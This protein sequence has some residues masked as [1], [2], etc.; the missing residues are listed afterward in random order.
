MSTVVVAFSTAPY[1]GLRPFYRHEGDIFFGREEQTDQL[2]RRLQE[3]RFLAVVGPSGCGKSSLVRAGM[4]AGLE[5]GYMADAG[6]RWRIAEMRPG[7]R[8]LRALAATLLESADLFP[9]LGDA[10]ASLVEAA[11]RRGPRGLI[12]LLDGS[13]I[14]DGTNLLLLV[15]QFEEIFR[16]RREGDTD[17]AEAFVSLLLATAREPG[18]PVYVVLTMRS[19][20]LGDCAV[21]AGLPE[22]LNES[23]F[24]TPRMT[25]EQ[26][27]RAIM[28]PARVFR[29]EV[30]EV[31]VASLLNELDPE[32]DQLPVLQHT[33]MRLWTRAGGAPPSQGA[34]E[35]VPRYGAVAPRKLDLD[36]YRSIG[37]LQS[38]L[39]KH[40]DETYG[41]LDTPAREIARPLF[42]LLTERGAN[43]RDVRRPVRMEE[44]MELT[45]APLD[46]VARVVEAFRRPDR[47]FLTPPAGTPLLPDTVIDISHESL[48]RQWHQLTLWVDKEAASAA[49][50]RRLAESARLWDRNETGLLRIP[51][52]SLAV[53][54]RNVEG[55]TVVWAARYGTPREFT[56][57]MQ[58]L[59]E[60]EVAHY[61]AERA[62]HRRQLKEL[63]NARVQVLVVAGLLA[64]TIVALA[65]AWQA[66]RDLGRINRVVLESR[67]SVKAQNDTAEMATATLARLI[68]YYDATADG[69]ARDA[70]YERV[71]DD[72]SPDSL[73]AQISELLRRTHDPQLPYAPS[74]YLY[75]WTD[76]HEDRLL[77]SIYSGK[78]AG[79]ENPY[80]TAEQV[81]PQLWFRVEVPMRG[82]LHNQ[83][84]VDMYCNTYRGKTSFF[85]DFPDYPAPDG[86][87][88]EGER[89]DCGLLRGNAFEPFAGKG[90][91]ARAVLYF[92]L[93]YPGEI[94]PRE[95]PPDSVSMLLRW[96]REYPVTDYERHRNGVIQKSQGNRNPLVDHP[97]WAERITFALGFRPPP[98]QDAQ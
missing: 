74:T 31:L 49:M 76:L 8:P 51:E 56:L 35:P 96:H 24:L 78:P 5:T 87:A 71:S 21:F 3:T 40:L 63:R 17:E 64:M 34:P 73:F 10:P 39:S 88:V 15:D 75:P 86:G 29:G 45:G 81:V 32:P 46:R 95:L 1:P 54:W 50:Y 55:P 67:D 57:T 85:A 11:L 9:R 53:E 62:E 4:I 52:L 93:R 18:L 60:S 36:G 12:E 47:S 72:G 42:T 26:C 25:R 6:S 83:F 66:N 94:S 79:G 89:P 77:R 80:L 16:Y 58:Y 22:A 38:A 19:D 90:L 44:V 14:D 69:G 33:L 7:H 43:R 37:G 82:D 65:F 13:P 20:F 98:S 28:G 27:R 48:I 97:E 92:L 84:A 91:V 70:Y 61:D 68:E 30:D 23:L 2:L 41:E 59:R